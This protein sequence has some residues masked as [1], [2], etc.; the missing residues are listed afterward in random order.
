[1]RVVQLDDLDVIPAPGEWTEDAACALLGVGADLFTGDRKPADSDLDLM[2]RICRRCRVRNECAAYAE[3][4]P[5]Y[6][7]WSG[8]WRSERSGTPHRKVA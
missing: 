4:W 5:V 3:T 1:M 6:G 7:M 2:A 8:V